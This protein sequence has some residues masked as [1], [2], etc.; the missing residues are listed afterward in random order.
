M[1]GRRQTSTGEAD[2]DEDEIHVNDGDIVQNDV[3]YR[4]ADTLGRKFPA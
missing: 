1:E 3:C 4:V 2:L